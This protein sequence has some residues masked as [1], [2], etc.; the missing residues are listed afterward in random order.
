MTRT[1]T[2]TKVAAMAV[3]TAFALSA[4]ATKSGGNA[5]SASND[6]GGSKSV[7]TVGT[8]DK[9]TSL[10]PA[11]AYDNG[12]FAVAV[13]SYG[14]LFSAPYGKAGVEPDLAESGEF[15]TPKQF[16]V[17]LKPG[18][19]FANGHDLTASDVKFSFDRMLKI[20][21]SN[22][23]SSLLY[24]LESTDAVDDTT[25]VFNLKAPNDQVFR[26]IL[27][28]AASP[29]VDEEVFSATE[30][31]PAEKIV[32][33]NAFAGQ[34]TIAKFDLNNLVQYKVNPNYKGSHGAPKNDGVNVK[35]FADS[36]NLKLNVQQGE[37]DVAYRSLSATDIADLKGNDKVKVETGPGGEIRYIVFNF[38]TMPFGAKQKD[39]DPNKARAVRQAMANLIN[40]EEL[41]TNV[42]KGTYTPL[43]SFVPAGLEASQ[44]PLKEMY[45]DGNGGPD[46]EKAKKVLADA[47]VQTPVQ[48]NMQYSP[49]HYG[50]SSGD[51]YAAIKSQLEK[52]GLFTVNLQSTEW[53]QYLKDRSSDVYPV[54]QLGWFPDYSDADNYLTPFFVKKNFLVNH[55]VNEDVNKM[56][57]E[58]AVEGDSAKRLQLLKDIQK[59]VAADLSTLPYLQGTQVAVVGKNIDGVTLDASFKFPYA[60]LTKK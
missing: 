40:R 44:E 46:V 31:T 48:I 34:Y 13:Q 58:Q 27:S 47:G 30:L 38:D 2:M 28:S 57:L 25:V 7:I 20:K 60:T 19:K 53:V 10:D 26:Q 5:S 41:S 37:I 42:Y 33:G 36:S 23:P 24:N 50:P 39:A 35:Y 32:E 45:G 51:E 14:F 15:T 4:C 1:V 9:V 59:A 49:D 6:G 16:T 8:T 11:G 29:I 52:D 18:L 12:S 17:K 56:I 55:Y 43:Y 54:Y 22:G 21:D 3:V